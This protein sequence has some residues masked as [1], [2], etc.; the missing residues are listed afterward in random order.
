[1][2]PTPDLHGAAMAA[3]EQDLARI[4]DRV[5]AMRSV[6]VRLLQDVV[7]AESRL[8]GQQLVQLVEANEQLVVSA[9]RDQT[10]TEN[11]VLALTETARKAEL[12]PLTQLPNRVLLFDRFGLAMT[13]ARRRSTRLALLFIDIDNFK[14]INDTFG[15]GVG[16]EVL[17]HVAQCLTAS[18]READTVSRQGGDEFVILLTEV[19]QPNDAVQVAEKLIAAL[20][21]PK[22]FGDHVLQLTASVGISVYPDHGDEAETLV[23]MADA[24]MYRAKRHGK[25]TYRV[26]GEAP[27]GIQPVTAPAPVDAPAPSLISHQRLH[28]QLQEANEQLV[29]SALNAQELQAAA[30]EARQRQSEFMAVVAHELRNP[31]APIR[32]AT[33]MLGRADVDETLLPRIQLIVDAQVAQISRVVADMIDV[34]NVGNAALKLQR[35]PVELAAVIDSAVDVCRPTMEARRQQFSLHL[36]LRL[37]EVHGDAVGLKQLFSN[38]LD[39]ASK[40]TSDG[41]SIGV[42]VATASSNAVITVSDNG[43]GIAPQALP[44][45]FEPFA[46]DIHAI[47]F[48]G[49]GSGIGLTAVRALAQAHGGRVLASSAG[50]GLGSQFTVTL[51]LLAPADASAG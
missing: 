8:A 9:L 51:P 11:A 41:G 15:H 20:G 39:N 46:Q 47:G 19:A 49:V 43:I 28:A 45:V 36:P 37:L 3:A 14:H 35:R 6:L 50:I 21:T 7:V 38:L 26:H 5:A 16:D 13:L 23:E 33:A 42:S 40:Y 12:D 4:T 27:T 24:A 32:V 10:D 17:K 25:G 29:L 30:E 18:V 48:N 44:Y 2:D 22:R 34:S 1:M 31:V